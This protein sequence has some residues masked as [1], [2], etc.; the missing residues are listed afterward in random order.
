MKVPVVK[1]KFPAP[2]QSVDYTKRYFDVGET[3]HFWEA[4]KP[5]P[6]SGKI[7]KIKC[8]SFG[9]VS[10]EVGALLIFPEDVM[11]FLMGGKKPH[12]S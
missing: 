12:V 4:I 5:K 9:R 7:T 6:A 11:R 3:I 2:G 10:Y 1:S 8:N